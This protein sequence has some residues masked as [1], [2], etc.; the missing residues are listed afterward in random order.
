[1]LMP[2]P[3]L[4]PKVENTIGLDCSDAVHCSAKMGVG[5]RA[6]LEAVVARVPPPSVRPE[7]GEEGAR[8]DARREAAAVAMLP[9]LLP[10]L[11]AAATAAATPRMWRVA[12]RTTRGLW[13][14]T[15]EAERA[16]HLSAPL[17]RQAVFTFYFS[18]CIFPPAPLTP[19]GRSF[20]TRSTSLTGAS[21]PRFASSME[22]SA[23]ATR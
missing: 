22:P 15:S 6:V 12:L 5:I 13:L 2:L 17:K 4:C 8:S 10:R 23:R 7:L 9:R 21:S 19:S 20:T 11:T 1:M 18:A 3:L 14:T 16:C